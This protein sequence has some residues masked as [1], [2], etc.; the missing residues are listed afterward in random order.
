MYALRWSCQHPGALYSNFIE[1]CTANGT[2][3][4]LLHQGAWNG[5]GRYAGWAALEA[6]CGRYAFSMGVIIVSQRIFHRSRRG[7]LLRALPMAFGV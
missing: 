2:L 4:E 7:T 6:D 3:G 5:I 1:L